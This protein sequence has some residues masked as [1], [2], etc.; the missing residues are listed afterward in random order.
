MVNY[1]VTVILKLLEGN[2]PPEKIQDPVRPEDVRRLGDFLKERL[3]RVASM[4]E[5]LQERGFCCRGTRKAVILEGSDLEAYQVK[6]LLQEHGF[7]PHE[8]EIKLEYTRQWG[9]M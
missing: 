3:E 8:Y 5:L 7:K 4:M 6:K 1:R 9:I 2:L